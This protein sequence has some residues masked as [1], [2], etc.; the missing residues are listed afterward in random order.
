VG[1]EDGELE[2]LEGGRKLLEEQNMHREGSEELGEVELEVVVLKVV[3]AVHILL[4][5]LSHQTDGET[6]LEQDAGQGVLQNHGLGLR[7]DLEL[8]H[9][10]LVHAEHGVGDHVLGQLDTPILRHLLDLS[11]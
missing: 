1:V 6:Q 11:Y 5:H 4:S 10:G 3:V 2:D 8:L 9:V 7:S